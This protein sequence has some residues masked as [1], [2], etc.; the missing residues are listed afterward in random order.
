[1]KTN[2]VISFLFNQIHSNV[3]ETSYTP[4]GFLLRKFKTPLIFF[5]FQTD[6]LNFIKE[7]TPHPFKK[8]Y[9]AKRDTN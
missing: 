9:N 5:P 8:I 7:A 2:C 3:E 1:M 6:L 4:E